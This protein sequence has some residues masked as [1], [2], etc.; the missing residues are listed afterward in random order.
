MQLQARVTSFVCRACCHV[1]AGHEQLLQHLGA[2]AIP[3]Q[4][5]VCCADVPA[6]WCSMRRSLTNGASTAAIP[7]GKSCSIECVPNRMP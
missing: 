2:D 6:L 1:T 4:N 3:Q 7:L 5:R